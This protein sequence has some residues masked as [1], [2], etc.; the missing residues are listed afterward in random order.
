MCYKTFK[1]T[2]G[3]HGIG[4]WC[5]TAQKSYFTEPPS[6]M[7]CAIIS[8]KGGAP[9]LS[10][11]SASR[12]YTCDSVHSLA[13]ADATANKSTRALTKS[14]LS[15]LSKSNG[16]SKI[17]RRQRRTKIRIYIFFGDKTRHLMVSRIPRTKYTLL[18]CM[19]CHTVFSVMDMSPT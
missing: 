16:S 1:W 8:S 7:S 18:D 4:W 19:W 17:K 15:I 14:T 9:P 10:S 13:C 2:V 6:L 5:R 3:G 12:L 11:S